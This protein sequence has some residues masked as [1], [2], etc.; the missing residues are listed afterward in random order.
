MAARR[1]ALEAGAAASPRATIRGRWVLRSDIAEIAPA[2]ERVVALCRDAGL[3]ARH[4]AFNIPI[5]LTEA[6]ANAIRCGNRG[7]PAR[8]VLLEA[9][10]RAGALV[11]EVSD[12][13]E[14]FDPARDCAD[15][16]SPEW[17]EREDGRGVFLM[18]ALMSTVEYRR[19]RHRRHR[20]TV[21]LELRRS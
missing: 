18:R 17:L 8:E 4:C 7:D 20:H 9:A 13:G 14:G 3:D 15:P 5:A 11:V 16:A 21:R 19:H 10:V 1:A 12:E 2:V 6:L